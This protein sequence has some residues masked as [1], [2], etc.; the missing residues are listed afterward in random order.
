MNDHDEDRW[1]CRKSLAFRQVDYR[2]RDQG[3][4]DENEDD[5]ASHAAI[6]AGLVEGI[7]YRNSSI[8]LGMPRLK[9]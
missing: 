1:G 4:Y 2:R 5:D 8:Y 6:M 7:N 9:D 3:G